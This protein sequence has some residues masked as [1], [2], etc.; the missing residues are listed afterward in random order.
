MI[1]KL[2]LN[3]ILFNINGSLRKMLSQTQGVNS[4]L[5]VSLFSLSV[6]TQDGLLNQGT[7]L[8]TH[9]SNVCKSSTVLS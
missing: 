5:P 6:Y 2:Q 8:E 7:T 4:C 3:I 9:N 1:A